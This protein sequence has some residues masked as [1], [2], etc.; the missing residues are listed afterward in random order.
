MNKAVILVALLVLGVAAMGVFAMS[1]NPSDAPSLG[2]VVVHKSPTCGCC[3]V[4]ASYLKR[5][6]Y[7]VEV[8]NTNDVEAK[9]QELGVPYELVSCHTSEVGGYVVEGHVPEEAVAKLLTEKPDI[10]GIGMAG[11]PAG[12]PGMGGSQAEPF[13]VYEILDDG[14]KGGVFMTL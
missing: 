11:M 8:H 14:S 5:Q 10:K 9:K 1:G 3:G 7:D 13:V 6:G 12:S 2:T 4:Y